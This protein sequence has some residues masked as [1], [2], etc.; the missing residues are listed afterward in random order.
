MAV[1]L[2]L[3]PEARKNLLSECSG[4]TGLVDWLDNIDRRP[5]LPELDT[6]LKG[7]DINLDA[8]RECIGYADDGYQRNVIKKTEFYELVANVGHLVK[9][10][11]FTITLA[12]IARS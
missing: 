6:H 4:L 8:L 1:Q 12:L 7:M 5:G 3:D 10:L 9:R 11:Q 2:E